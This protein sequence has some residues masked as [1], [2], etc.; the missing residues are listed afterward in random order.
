MQGDVGGIG[1]RRREER[2]G[3]GRSTRVS[4]LLQTELQITGG[5]ERHGQDR[6]LHTQVKAAMRGMTERCARDMYAC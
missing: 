1:I 2:E 3:R 4:V 6:K 5:E